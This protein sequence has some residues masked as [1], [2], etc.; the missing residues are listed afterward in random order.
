MPLEKLFSVR[1]EIYDFFSVVK[2]KLCANSGLCVKKIIKKWRSNIKNIMCINQS[3]LCLIVRIL[4]L[5]LN[6]KY[7]I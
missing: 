1:T 5:A 4:K 3:S 2:L 7:Y 6:I